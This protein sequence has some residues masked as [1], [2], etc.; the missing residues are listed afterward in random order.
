MWTVIHPIVQGDNIDI[1]AGTNDP[2][3]ADLPSQKAARGVVLDVIGQRY[4][5]A[6]LRVHDSSQNF[7]GEVAFEQFDAIELAD[8]SSG[9]AAPYPE[10][11][12][13]GNVT[14]MPRIKAAPLEVRIRRY[15]PPVCRGHIQLVTG[16]GIVPA[17][18]QS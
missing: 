16:P 5:W 9:Q 13:F 7:C 12:C 2:A 3:K 10:I 6:E 14:P 11:Q 17:C 15:H 8:Q 4:E 1:I 18:R